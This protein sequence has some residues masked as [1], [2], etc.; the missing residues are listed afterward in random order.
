VGRFP[1]AAPEAGSTIPAP[2]TFCPTLARFTHTH[3]P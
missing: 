2:E 3:R 1:L